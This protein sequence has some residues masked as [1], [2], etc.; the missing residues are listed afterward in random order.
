[1]DF[2]IQAAA[3]HTAQAATD[4]AHKPLPSCQ[5]WRLKLHIA[6]CALSTLPAASLAVL[7]ESLWRR[8]LLFLFANIML[9]EA[10]D[11]CGGQGLCPRLCMAAVGCVGVTWS[12]WG[13]V[14]GG[15]GGG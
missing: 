4:H 3:G 2:P 13:H 6:D 5:H 10:G 8:C 1:M 7:L 9:L 14:Q 11:G 15:A 12:C